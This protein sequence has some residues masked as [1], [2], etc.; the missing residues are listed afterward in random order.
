MRSRL[1]ALSLAGIDFVPHVIVGLYNGE[2]KGEFEALNMIKPYKP[3]ALVVISSLIPGTG[4][5][6]N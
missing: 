2:L 4:M 6:K 1:R 5:A 3:S